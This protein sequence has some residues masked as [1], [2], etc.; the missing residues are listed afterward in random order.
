MNLSFSERDLRSCFSRKAASAGEAYSLER[1][2]R[3]LTVGN[4]G[5]RLQAEGPGTPPHPYEVDVLAARVNGRLQVKG[6]CSC[7]VW[8]DCKHAAAVLFA[9][10]DE[11][12]E[13]PDEAP[14]SP[15]RKRLDPALA[16]WIE[17]LQEERF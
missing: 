12:G 7:P 15:K 10:L 9:A 6:R 11:S 8:Y 3:G 1:R 16:S 13:R 17:G 4:G 2:V 14:A 5:T